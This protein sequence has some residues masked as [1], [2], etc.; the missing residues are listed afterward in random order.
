MPCEGPSPQ[1]LQ[2]QL[3]CMLE[4]ISH[5]LLR[6]HMAS[7]FCT[8]RLLFS[9][10]HLRKDILL[11][12]SFVGLLS[13]WFPSFLPSFFPCYI[14]FRPGVPTRI[15]CL[16]EMP[17]MHTDYSMYNSA[18]S[19]LY[20][21]FLLA[22]EKYI[23]LIYSKLVAGALVELLVSCLNFILGGFPLMNFQSTVISQK[24]GS[25]T[26]FHTKFVQYQTF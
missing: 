10:F 13:F 23:L 16:I 20:Y 1:R 14:Y 2:L 26:S 4:D 6:I 18:S 22:R 24:P 12:I 5:T 15:N 8:I 9:L 25:N 7:V 3:E 11:Y 21:S 17:E 19:V